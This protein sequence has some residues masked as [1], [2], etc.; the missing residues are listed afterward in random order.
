MELT[1]QKRFSLTRQSK[2]EGARERLDEQ[3]AFNQA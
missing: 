3:A 2:A 1:A